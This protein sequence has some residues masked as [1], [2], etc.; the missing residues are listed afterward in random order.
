MA[1]D[2]PGPEPC[3]RGGDDRGCDEEEGRK[4][5]SQRSTLIRFGKAAPTPRARDSAAG[6]APEHPRQPAH[7]EVHRSAPRGDEEGRA[8]RAAR[9]QQARQHPEARDDLVRTESGGARDG[10]ARIPAEGDGGDEKED[11]P[12]RHGPEKGLARAPDRER[13][14]EHGNRRKGGAG[15]EKE[16]PDARQQPQRFLVA[17]PECRRSARLI[18]D[19]QM[20]AFRFKMHRTRSDALEGARTS[21]VAPPAPGPALWLRSI[22]PL[23]R[24][25]LFERPGLSGW[26][27]APFLLAGAWGVAGWAVVAHPS[28]ASRI[29]SFLVIG[30]ALAAM[31]VVLHEAAHGNLMRRPALNRWA[32]FL[33]GA[34]VLVPVSA[35]RW[36]HLRHHRQ[37]L[38]ASAREGWI[39]GTPAYLVAVPLAAFRFGEAGIRRA[40]AVECGL[41]A[42]LSGGALFLAARTGSLRALADAWLFPLVLA[43]AVT[44]LRGLTETVADRLARDRARPA[45]RILAAPFGRLICDHLEHHLCPSVPWRNLSRLGRLARRSFE[46]PGHG[47][48][49][50]YLRFLWGRVEGEGPDAA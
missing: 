9:E 15:P 33:F 14:E 42:A 34:P 17:R 7:P 8:L 11:L 38:A 40:A 4:A 16:D 35:Y 6:P 12:G 10:A 26:L 21:L 30:I 45:E 31:D 19:R 48:A 36:Y 24:R 23:E 41:I 43:V 3:A 47:T 18:A 13:S 46:T 49:R 22:E 5:G 32:G 37:T 44:S 27:A 2:E 28:P 29:V 39:N 20:I 1:G 50:P 25:A